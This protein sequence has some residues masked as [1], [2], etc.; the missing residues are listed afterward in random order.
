ML[1]QTQVVKVVDYFK[2]WMKK[3]PS[4]EVLASSSLEDVFTLWS[5]LGYYRRARFLYEGAK[6]IQQQPFPSTREALLRV[7]GIGAYTSSAIA[8][9]AFEEPVLVVDG[10]VERVW[11]RLMAFSRQDGEAHFKRNINTTAASFEPALKALTES[12]G[13]KPSHVAQGFMELGALI[14]RPKNPACAE[15]PLSKECQT[16][17]QMK[18]AKSDEINLYEQYPGPKVRPE[19]ISVTEN[20]NIILNNDLDKILVLKKTH[21]KWRQGLYEFPSQDELVA[22]ARKSIELWTTVEKSTV[23]NHRILTHLKVLKCT[24]HKLPTEPNENVTYKWVKVTDV[25]N[26]KLPISA[27]MHRS[28]VRVNKALSDPPQ[29]KPEK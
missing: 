2:R 19:F 23:T 26:R 8:A 22:L 18:H 6:S 29:L 28:L 9:I 17:Q 11:A 12:G 27:P 24:T 13:L 4:V 3:F 16:Y 14:C 5:G 15:C 21:S 10:N 1:Q 25:L 7:K 20:K